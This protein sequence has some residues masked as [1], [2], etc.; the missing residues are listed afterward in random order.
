MN[1]LHR[2]IEDHAVHQTH[3]RFAGRA[4]VA[5]VGRRME[6][7]RAIGRDGTEQFSLCR[8]SSTSDFSIVVDLVNVNMPNLSTPSIKTKCMYIHTCRC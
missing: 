4:D 6:A 7:I 1:V 5:P 2:V 3:T 8:N